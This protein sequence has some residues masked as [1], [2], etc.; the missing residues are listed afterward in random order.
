MDERR[1]QIR[2][3][4]VESD[5]TTVDTILSALRA[6]D[7]R[8]TV[9]G[10]AADAR[11]I[12]AR[13]PTD[14]AVVGTVLPDGSGFDLLDDL[15]RAP[16]GPPVILHGAADAAHDVLRGWRA[17]AVDYLLRPLSAAELRASVLRATRQ[18]H[19]IVA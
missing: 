6:F 14:V 11:R 5:A 17:G 7:L 19:P 3:L 9:A 18:S 10:R 12:V 2:M 4:I 15:R 13:A 1:V 8:S 16:N